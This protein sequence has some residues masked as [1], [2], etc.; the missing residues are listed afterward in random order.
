MGTIWPTAGRKRSRRRA[1]RQRHCLDTGAGNPTP[2]WGRPADRRA[3]TGGEVEVRAVALWHAALMPNGPCLG[4]PGT[5][6]PARHRRL[7]QRALP[8]PAFPV[9]GTGG[10]HCGGVLESTAF[11]GPAAGARR[12]RGV[13]G[14]RLG[15][16]EARGKQACAQGCSV[17]EAGHATD[18]VAL[19]A[20]GSDRGYSKCAG[21]LHRAGAL[22]LSPGT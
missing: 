18:L 22:P 10:M 1:G 7:S 11:M 17:A 15:G 2:R 19:H 5:A 9:E 6:R 4:L 20:L 13:G 16:A 14:R 21:C 12:R 8:T 3:R